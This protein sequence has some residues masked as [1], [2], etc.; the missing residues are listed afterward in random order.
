MSGPEV[1]MVDGALKRQ[2]D[3]LVS[4][5]IVFRA[6][7]TVDVGLGTGWNG[8]IS[9]D[10]K[11]FD[12]FVAFDG[13]KF[14]PKIAGYYRLSASVVFS[15]GTSGAQLEVAIGK[16][17]T[18]ATMNTSQQVT[19]LPAFRSDGWSGANVTDLIYLNGTTDYAEVYNWLSAGATLRGTSGERTS[20]S[21]ELVGVSA[22]VI[23]EP[24]HKIGAAGEP[25][26]AAGWSNQYSDTDTYARFY[27]DPHGVVHVAG[28]IKSTGAGALAFTL[29]V[30]YRPLF[31]CSYPLS[32]W[33][34]STRAVGVIALGPD[35][36]VR[37]YGGADQVLAMSYVN[38]DT[39]TFR[40]E[41]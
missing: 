1:L 18:V 41:Q 28:S 31:S 10:T 20:F 24:W 3:S 6:V 35:G 13:A 14:Q 32:Y 27:R 36:G 37:V 12:P 21:A 19:A 22:G 4:Q 30:G 25:A 2:G 11:T 39:I 29:P 33:T 40:A 5:G 23:P 16:N 15:G 17:G 38:L 34:G 26:F 8:P 9:F 7:K